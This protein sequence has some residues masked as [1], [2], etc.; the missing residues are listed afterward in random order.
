[1]KTKDKIEELERRIKELEGRPQYVPVYWPIYVQP[2]PAYVPPPVP[3]FVPPGMFPTPSYP[4]MPTGP[5][6]ISGYP[7]TCE[8]SYSGG[9]GDGSMQGG[10]LGMAS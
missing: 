3:W 4:A 9:L 6:W 1:V 10:T 7:T 8:V 5:I 2:V